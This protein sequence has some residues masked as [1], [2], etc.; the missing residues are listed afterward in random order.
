[1]YIPAQVNHL[2]NGY[3]IGHMASVPECPWHHVGECLIGLDARTMRKTLGPSRKLHKKQFRKIF[4]TDEELL[5]ITNSYVQAFELLT[6]GGG[7]VENSTHVTETRRQTRRV[8]KNGFG[9]AHGR[10]HVHLRGH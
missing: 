1:M 9:T 7:T 4:G 5:A 8:A 2:L 10:V 3:R 6:I